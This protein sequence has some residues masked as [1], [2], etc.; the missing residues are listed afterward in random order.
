MEYT[1]TWFVSSSLLPNKASNT[2]ISP[3]M[4]PTALSF[5]R[6][7]SPQEYCRDSL[8]SPHPLNFGL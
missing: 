3:K 7:K 2:M 4:T 8:A 1:P 6:M 5:K